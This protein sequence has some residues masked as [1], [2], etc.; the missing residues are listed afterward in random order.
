MMNVRNIIIIRTI[1]SISDPIIT[2]IPTEM[3]N[4]AMNMLFRGSTK[5]STACLGFVIPTKTPAKNAPI[6]TDNPI[7]FAAHANVN[8][9]P[10][11]NR[12]MSSSLDLS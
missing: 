1:L 8:A 12:E 3:K 6:A 4:M 5:C 9:A 10:M 7:P 11:H 2:S